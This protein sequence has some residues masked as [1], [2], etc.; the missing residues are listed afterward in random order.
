MRSK[1]LERIE[2]NLEV[3]HI[4]WTWCIT[5]K[6]PSKSLNAH[7]KRWEK[8][9]HWCWRFWVLL[10]VEFRTFCMWWPT[11]EVCTNICQHHTGDGGVARIG[12]EEG[13]VQLVPVSLNHWTMLLCRVV[14]KIF[15]VNSSE[16]AA[17]CLKMLEL[18]TLPRSWPRVKTDLSRNTC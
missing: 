16:I 12:C 1:W 2:K 13:L 18:A 15:N 3:N 11:F 8:T 6:F 4:N 7:Y 14:E 5:Y 9:S 10:V 17:E